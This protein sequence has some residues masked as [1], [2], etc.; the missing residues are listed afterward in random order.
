MEHS[1]FGMR[2][3]I[4]GQSLFM[5]GSKNE[6]D[7][8]MIVA[9]N[10]PPKTVI[11]IYLQRWEIETLFCSLKSKGWRLE[12]TRV[13]HIKRL[14]KLIALLAVAF[15]WAHHMGEFQARQKPIP[16]KKLRK[17]RRP[18]NS[19]FRLGLDCLRDLLTSF[20][21]NDRNFKK[22]LRCLVPDQLY[23]RF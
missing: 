12:N 16:L 4:F 3:T 10:Q 11:A 15:V 22:Y 17:Q 13:T 21:I 14:E 8:L 19:F 20:N 23:L 2:I 1:A 9:T 6:R 5:A 7:E 18:Q